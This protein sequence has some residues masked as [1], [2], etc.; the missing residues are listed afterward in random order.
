[1][2]N[3]STNSHLPTGTGV[4]KGP[5]PI[6]RPLTLA[7]EELEQTIE[8]NEL[9]LLNFKQEFGFTL[10]MVFSLKVGPANVLTAPLMRLKGL[11][12][13]I[14]TDNPPLADITAVL[15]EIMQ[16]LQQL[17]QVSYKNLQDVVEHITAVQQEATALPVKSKVTAP[18]SELATQS[19]QG[20]PDAVE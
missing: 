19:R 18:G 7:E 13:K 9:A 1:M 11:T 3:E 16:L 20:N 5:A 2:Y 15:I 6:S 8:N 4:V 17:M 14:D 10:L 12:D